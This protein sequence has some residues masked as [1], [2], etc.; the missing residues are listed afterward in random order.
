MV[1][2]RHSIFSS[3][4]TVDLDYDRTTEK[5]TDEQMDEQAGRWTDGWKDRQMD[6]WTYEHVNNRKYG[7]MCGLTYGKI[8]SWT[9]R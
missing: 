8:N 5:Q 1:E 6:V 9:D 2:Y 4:K 7:E 3:S